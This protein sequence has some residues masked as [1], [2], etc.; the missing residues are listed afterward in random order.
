MWR[1]KRGFFVV[2]RLMMPWQ[3]SRQ[4]QTALESVYNG[5]LAT[6][7]AGLPIVNTALSVQAVGF[8]RFDGDWLGVLLTPWCMNL[9]LLPGS[10]STWLNGP[11]GVCVEKRFPYGTFAF[12]VGHEGQLGHFAQC[13][14]FS[15][16]FEFADQAAA[17]ATAQAVLQNLLAVPEPR[18]LSRRDW[19][20]GAIGQR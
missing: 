18:G 8:A 14:L 19:L 11:I 3:D 13:S 5:I 1:Q 20:R 16:M 2:G 12:T 17:L 6:R 7:M 10:D 15:P 4:I 9:F